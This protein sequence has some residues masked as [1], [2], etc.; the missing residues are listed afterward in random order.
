MPLN[1]RFSDAPLGHEILG[2]DLS[3]PIP[4]DVF[5]EIEK[6]YDIYGVIIFRG[7][8]L[9]PQQQIT[10]S[11]RFGGLT[12][13]IDERFNMKDNPEIFIVSNEMEDGRSK[14]LADAGRYWHTDMWVTQTPPRG[15]I[16]Y[17][18]AVP[19]DEKGEPLGD[20]YF[21]STAAAYDALPEDLRKRMEGRKAVFSSESYHSARIARTPKDPVTGQ[22]SLDEQE[23]LARRKKN[24]TQEHPLIKTH[25]RSGRKCIYFSEEAMSHVVGLSPAE[26]A[27]LLD[28]IHR[29]MLQPQF[30]YRHR[31]AV[32]DLVMW[33]NIAC[34]HKAT[35]DFDLPLIRTMHRTTLASIQTVAA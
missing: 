5:A 9:T 7:Q 35:G 23:R 29:H 1:I 2:V 8:S 11:K 16:L 34:M 14:G 22:Y 13:Y 30:I 3:K 19:H 31:W 6:A 4:D 26:S 20:T 24:V 33:D 18:I 27:E 28:D 25:P 15:S 10:F 12:Q 21:A 32:G 17:A